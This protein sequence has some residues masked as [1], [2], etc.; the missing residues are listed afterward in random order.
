MGKNTNAPT[1]GAP[2]E[3]RLGSVLVSLLEPD[4]GREVEFHRW[5]ERDHFYSG[6]MVGAHFFAGRRFV[7][8]RALKDQR[9]PKRDS[10]FADVR[11]GSYLAL[12]WILA[13]HHEEAVALGRRSRPES[14]RA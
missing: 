4:R 6:C 12:Y 7:A 10:L 3:V 5:Y 14:D 9:L 1:S 2:A 8:T 11:D 13:G